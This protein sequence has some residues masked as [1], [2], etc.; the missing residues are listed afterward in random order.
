MFFPSTNFHLAF[1]LYIT[2]FLLFLNI[3]N[4]EENLPQQ[5]I[6]SQCTL[7]HK[8]SQDPFPSLAKC[9][10]Y[11]NEACCVSVHDEY[12][13]TQINKLLSSSCIRK[14]SNLETLMCFGCHPK[15]SFYI[16]DKTIRICKGFAKALWNATED[17]ELYEKTT[18]FDN[19][20]FKTEFFKDVVQYNKKIEDDERI[21][22]NSYIIPS[23]VFNNITEFFDYIKIPFFEDYNIQIVEQTSD[24]C[25]NKEVYL[26]AH[27]GLEII[28][29][30]ILFLL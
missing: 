30:I 18:I 12:I 3:I 5:A 16:K 15:E 28:L 9:Y 19:C 14:Y 1:F 11:N 23:E 27:K 10:K 24:N 22:N 13:N 4:C 20:G 21:K 29:G 6:S 2:I 17:K 26:K 25:Y 7:T 8:Q